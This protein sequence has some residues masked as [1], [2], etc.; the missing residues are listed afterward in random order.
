VPAAEGPIN[1]RQTVTLTSGRYGL[2]VEAA[3]C[4]NSRVGGSPGPV[5][6]NKSEFSLTLK[7]DPVRP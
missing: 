3:A 5:D 7:F 2:V 1:T 4:N 6:N